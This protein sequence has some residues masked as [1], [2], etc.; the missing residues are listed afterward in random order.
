MGLLLHEFAFASSAA[1]V[2][3]H[4]GDHTVATVEELVE[5][6]WESADLGEAAHRSNHLDGSTANT[7]FN[8]IWG[9]TYSMSDVASSRS[10]F[11]G[12]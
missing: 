12:S 11:S 3:A 4:S 7:R 5:F 6:V 1:G 9:L 8:C 10:H 2:P